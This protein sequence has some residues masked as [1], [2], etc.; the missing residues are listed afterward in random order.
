LEV[1]IAHLVGRSDLLRIERLIVVGTQVSWALY[2]FVG[3]G[4]MLFGPAIFHIWTAGR[5]EFS[6]SLMALYLCMSAGN[7]LGRVCLHALNS[8]NRL[9][10]PSFLMLCIAILALGLGAVLALPLGVSGMV[11]GGIVG[12]VA[13]SVVVIF[14]V[15]SWL[16]QSADKLLADFL[17]FRGSMRVIRP[18]LH[19]ALARIGLRH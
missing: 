10:G 7:L 1:E 4:L 17:N 15:A 5:I 9:Y 16:G 8:T 19:D 18:H 14:S 6:R 2:L 12:E 3:A 13:N 11:L